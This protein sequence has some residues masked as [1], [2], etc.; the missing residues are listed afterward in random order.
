[1]ASPNVL[2]EH[3]LR[4]EKGFIIGH[5]VYS[6]PDA[7]SLGFSAPAPPSSDGGTA[8]RSSSLGS[9]FVSSP[10]FF[11][12]C[13]AASFVLATSFLL[14]LMNL[15]HWLRWRA[16]RRNRGTQRPP[17]RRRH[18]SARLPAVKGPQVRAMRFLALISVVAPSARCAPARAAGPRLIPSFPPAALRCH[19]SRR[20]AG[21]G[22][23]HGGCAPSPS[24][25][26]RRRRAG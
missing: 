8:S 22:H 4:G 15:V 19:L 7:K 14:S 23:A 6:C 20:R 9:A 25:G 1:M 17:S 18:R 24:S 10:L 26:R 21:A 3:C 2:H 5:T 16:Y 13:L 12:L 11:F